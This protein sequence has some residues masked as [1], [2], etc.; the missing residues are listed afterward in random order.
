MK[1]AI[2]LEGGKISFYFG[3]CLQLAFFEIENIKFSVKKLLMLLTY[4]RGISCYAASCPKCVM[5]MVRV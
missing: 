4:Q 1:I 3:R 5:K 2:P